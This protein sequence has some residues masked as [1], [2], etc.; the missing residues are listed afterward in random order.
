MDTR[1]ASFPRKEAA[2]FEI[3]VERRMDFPVDGNFCQPEEI[4]RK[5]G[6]RLP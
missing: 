5:T 2:L 1:I 6:N 3:T 4:Y